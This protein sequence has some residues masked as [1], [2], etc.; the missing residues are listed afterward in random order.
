MTE[1]GP[2]IPALGLLVFAPTTAIRA[3]AGIEI[4]NRPGETI[5][6]VDRQLE[7]AVAE[8]VIAMPDG[9]A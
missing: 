7:R 6:G 2:Y 1:L 3:R 8:V 9:P 4:E 5:R